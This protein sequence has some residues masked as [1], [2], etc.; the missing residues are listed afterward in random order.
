MRTAFEVGLDRNTPAYAGKTETC[1]PFSEIEGNTPAYAGKTSRS[2]TTCTWRRKHPR[3]RGEDLTPS[4]TPDPLQ[5]TPPLT[6]G[7]RGWSPR[8]RGEP[9]NTP[10]YAGKTGNA[11]FDLCGQGKHPRLRG[12]DWKPSRIRIRPLETPPLTRG[13]QQHFVQRP[14]S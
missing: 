4:Q 11:D 8:R 12:E 13:R 3:L 10:A 1:L 7:R 14:V 9:R 5:E 2:W 6:R